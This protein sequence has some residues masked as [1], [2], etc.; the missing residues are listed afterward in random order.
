MRGQ[1]MKTPKSHFQAELIG[2]NVV[3]INFFDVSSIISSPIEIDSQ[4]YRRIDVLFSANRMKDLS[5]Q[6]PEKSRKVSFS[7]NEKIATELNDDWNLF[8]EHIKDQG[9]SMES[10]VVNHV[11]ANEVSQIVKNSTD[12]AA[13]LQKHLTENLTSIHDSFVSKLETYSQEHIEK[14]DKVLTLL[15]NK[16]NKLDKIEKSFEKT[17]KMI[18]GFLD[19]ESQLEVAKIKDEN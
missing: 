4:K 19:L 9:G 16:L 6:E 10:R 2:D 3:S 12:S 17:M 5:G 7:C 1:K 8:M 14:S 18:D 15:V 13:D 11:I